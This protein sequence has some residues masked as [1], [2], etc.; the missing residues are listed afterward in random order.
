MVSQLYY[1]HSLSRPFIGLHPFFRDLSVVNSRVGTDAIA[2]PRQAR[3]GSLPKVTP[4]LDS[5]WCRKSSVTLG[6]GLRH[7]RPPAT[8]QSDATEPVSFTESPK[9]DFVSI[10]QKLPLLSRRQRNRILAARG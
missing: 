10:F 7:N 2:R 9:D 8:S 5:L 3:L 6:R 4:T 1:C